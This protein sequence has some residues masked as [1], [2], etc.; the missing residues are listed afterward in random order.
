MTRILSIIF[1]LNFSLVW[2][3]K[4]TT[5]YYTKTYRTTTSI[6][7][8]FF[9]DDVKVKSP[10]E[11]EIVNYYRLQGEWKE[12]GRENIRKLSPT[13]IEI[14]TTRNQKEVRIRR[15]IKPVENGYYITDAQGSLILEEGTSSMVFPLI[16]E[17]VWKKYN[18]ITGNILT[19]G[20][21]ENNQM[22]SNKF[23]IDDTN[24]IED[25]FYYVDKVAEFKGGLE[26]FSRKVADKV[27]YRQTPMENGVTG[28]VIVGFVVMKD[29][30]IDGISLLRKVRPALDKE[31]L[32]AVRSINA[33]WTPGE[34]NHE[35]VN[36]AFS[37]SVNF[38]QQ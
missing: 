34:I 4:D 7:E 3:Q 26:A 24:Y 18:E 13:A 9:Y 1:L 14:T 29:G 33:K 2:G 16:R 38:M 11:Y 5:I 6:D 37:I 10:S 25:V 27:T 32:R 15:S 22:K 23:W 36:M 19:E 12:S 28:R 21:Y 17:G 8:A 30:S 31:A 35:K 20:I